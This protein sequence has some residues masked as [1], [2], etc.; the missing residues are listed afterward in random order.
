MKAVKFSAKA[1]LV[2]FSLT[3]IDFG[4]A[5]YRAWDNVC[6]SEYDMRVVAAQ[7]GRATQQIYNKFNT[8]LCTFTKAGKIL[9][10]SP[11]DFQRVNRAQA[12]LEWYCRSVQ[13]FDQAMC[14]M[15]WLGRKPSC[16]C[17]L[18]VHIT[19]NTEI[20]D[21]IEMAVVPATTI[22]VWL[23]QSISFCNTLCRV[24]CWG[25]AGRNR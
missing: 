12:R 16:H 17:S 19:Y 23:L 18:Q 11:L 14:R 5:S 9:D 25:W 2:A 21:N 4:F 15:I 20:I 24:L 13:V 10:I 6:A 3:C 7:L 1:L 8:F 22:L